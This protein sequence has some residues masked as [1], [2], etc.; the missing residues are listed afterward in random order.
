MY[1]S[2]TITVQANIERHWEEIYPLPIYKWRYYE[3]VVIILPRI[4]PP[5]KI[6][7]PIPCSAMPITS[8]GGK[9]LGRPMLF[10]K[11]IFVDQVDAYAVYVTVPVMCK[12][13]WNALTESWKFPMPFLEPQIKVRSVDIRFIVKYDC[14]NLIATV[15]CIV[16]HSEFSMN[17]IYFL[18]SHKKTFNSNGAIV[19]NHYLFCDDSTLHAGIQRVTSWISYD[20]WI[21]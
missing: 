16:I 3:V 6:W 21:E 10:F 5:R 18:I 12:E 15:L 7:L 4:K 20:I 9:L 14:K 13:M 11:G 8:K 19:T 1:C 2:I 17:I